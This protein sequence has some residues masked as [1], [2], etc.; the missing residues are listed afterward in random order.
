MSEGES[1]EEKSASAKTLDEGLWII[2]IERMLR[3]VA[4]ACLRVERNEC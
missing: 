2:E 1:L 4:D 3:G